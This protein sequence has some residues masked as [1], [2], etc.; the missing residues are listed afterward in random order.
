MPWRL[1][2]WKV[3]D[4]GCC[5]RSPRFPRPAG[6]PDPDRPAFNADCVF[7]L[8]QPGGTSPDGSTWRGGCQLYTE[9]LEAITAR[10]A[11]NN[12]SRVRL[13]DLRAK[14]GLVSVIDANTT[15][16]LRT[17]RDTPIQWFLDTCWKWPYKSPLISA[18]WER[19]K[20]LGLAHEDDGFSP[21]LDPA[22]TYTDAEREAIE[23]EFHVTDA[24]VRAGTAIAEEPACCFYWEQVP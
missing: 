8:N 17:F 6:G 11:S 4:G 18:F 14:A 15:P 21:L 19:V 1:S 5:V 9:I 3:C 16:Q 7:H 10:N 12:M 23:Q 24:Q 20:A 13:S 22:R 2:R